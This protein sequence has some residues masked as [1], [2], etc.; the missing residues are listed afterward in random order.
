MAEKTNSAGGMNQ[1]SNVLSNS[2][3]R[4]DAEL[5]RRVM[6][7]KSKNVISKVLARDYGYIKE[8]ERER[9]ARQVMTVPRDS[10]I[11]IGHEE[12]YVD[13][14]Q[15][16]IGNS[17]LEFELAE[18]IE[19]INC[20]TTTQEE[21]FNWIEEGR[22]IIAHCNDGE[23]TKDDEKERNDFVEQSFQR[24]IE[25]MTCISLY[26]HNRCEGAAA[27][28]EF[29]KQKLLKLREIRSAIL[30]S[31]KNKADEKVSTKEEYEKAVEYRRLLRQMKE[32]EELREAGM[33]QRLLAEK[34][35]LG[36]RHDRDTDLTTPGFFYGSL[37]LAGM[38]QNDGY[39]YHIPC[40]NSPAERLALHKARKETREDVQH[41]LE[42]LSGRRP[43]LKDLP[44][45][46]YDNIRKRMFT[47]EAFLRAFDNLENTH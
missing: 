9:V 46:D 41:R 4:N 33:A 16:E 12:V 19:R 27:K 43:P 32:L 14:F 15:N 7:E 31:T 18:S 38:M 10:V 23:Y 21:Y 36:C 45:Y 47:K 11:K 17:L 28:C 8:E 30:N 5:T 26:E 29:L 40:T 6:R 1:D 39:T 20:G 44:S 35:R 24:E 2:S 13:K 25:L 3:A 22:D 42:I 37:V 34:E